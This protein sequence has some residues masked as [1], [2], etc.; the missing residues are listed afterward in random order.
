MKDDNILTGNNPQLAKLIGE[1]N[2]MYEEENIYLFWDNSNIHFVGM[3]NV[4]PVREP[5]VDP[6]LYRT[7]FKNL[8]NVVRAFKHRKIRKVYMIGSIPPKDD[9]LW[10]YIQSLNIEL[11]TLHRTAENKEVGVDESLQVHMQQII[12]DEPP[13]TI[14]LLSGDGA[15][16]NL[17]I[18]FLQILNSAVRHGWKA[19]VYSWDAGCSGQI[20]KFANENDNAD[21]VRLDD[22][23]EQ[24]TFIKGQRQATDYKYTVRLG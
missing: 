8:L 20:K 23:Y 3:N 7:H 24:I 11:R 22:Y 2:G 16:S 1:D 18:G 14:A 6:Q 4:L 13:G 17:G 12:L 5:S 19:Q 9:V 15:A 21:Y 10:A